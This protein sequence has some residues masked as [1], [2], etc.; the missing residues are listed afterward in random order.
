MRF[1]NHNKPPARRSTTVFARTKG[2]RKNYKTPSAGFNVLTCC[3]T[4]MPGPKNKIG[5]KE[6]RET[7]AASHTAIHHS[8][9]RIPQCLPIPR[10]S[11]SSFVISPF[12]SFVIV[13]QDR[14][15]PSPSIPRHSCRSVA[16][17][18]FRPPCNALP[19]APLRLRV[20]H[21]EPDLHREYWKSDTSWTNKSPT[22]TVLRA[23]STLCCSLCAS[24]PLRET[25]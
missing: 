20:K 12:P 22:R 17:N 11:I 16:P 19:S 2:G 4:Q 21:Q 13:R 7:N 15:V 10:F 24:A 18:T 8:A 5:Q 6:N 14:Q 23:K 3:L 25:P 9:R 1:H